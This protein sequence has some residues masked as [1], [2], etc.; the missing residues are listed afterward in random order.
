[1]SVYTALSSYL[2]GQRTSEIP[3]TFSDIER[4]LGR[5]LPSSSYRHQ[6][7]WAN[8]PTG[9]SHC[10][11]WTEA[12]WATERVDLKNR[13]VVFRKTKNEKAPPQASPAASSNPAQLFGALRGSVSIKAPLDAPSGESWNAQNG[14]V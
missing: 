10:R 8:N 3:L 12:G 1:M 13:S 7:W 6:A 2:A 14:Q 9:H 4:I 11:A 5:S